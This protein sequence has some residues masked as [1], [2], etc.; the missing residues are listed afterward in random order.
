MD[1]IAFY[2]NCKPYLQTK[3]HMV[4]MASIRVKEMPGIYFFMDGEELVYVG[5]S[6][7]M[8]K[9]WGQHLKKGDKEFTHYFFSTDI[10]S[11]D[12][13]VKIEADIIY[14]HRPKYN[15]IHNPDNLTYKKR[16]QAI[17]GK[18]IRQKREKVIVVKER[19]L[20]SHYSPIRAKEYL[21]KMYAK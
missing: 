7:N 10:T 2:E 20:E 18:N 6:S 15:L 3:G 11:M 4:V 5:I 1:K 21:S 13:L 9:R 17:V 16:N 8:P 19:Q 12:D 14:T